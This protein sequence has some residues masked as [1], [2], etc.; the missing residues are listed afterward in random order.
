[1]NKH[2]LQFLYLEFK[3][4][5]VILLHS[6]FAFLVL[7]FLV[8]VAFI[9]VTFAA[10]SA[11]NYAKIHVG[12]VLPP[13]NQSRSLKLMTSMIEN[14]ESTSKIAEISY[15]GQ[16]EAYE[17]IRDGSLDAAIIIGDTF[18]NDVMTGINTPAIVLIPEE[19]ILNVD[20]FHELIDDGVS[21]IKT[22]ESA[23]YSVTECSFVKPMIVERYQ[24]E[25]FLTQLY[26][27]KAISL[28]T[29][30]KRNKITA[31]GNTSIQI[32]YASIAICILISFLGIIFSGLY[33]EQ[34]KVIAKKLK[35]Y[36]LGEIK[37]A[38]IR[39][40][41]I[42]VIVLVLFLLFSFGMDAL[43]K[44]MGKGDFPVEAD[45]LEKAL[46]EKDTVM[47]L[48]NPAKWGIWIIMS[49]SI[50][51]FFHTIL[52][53]SGNVWTNVMILIQSV[54]YMILCGGSIFPSA[55]LPKALDSISNLL[56]FGYWRSAV[57]ILWEKKLENGMELALKLSFFILAMVIILIL[58][59]FLSLYQ[60][61]KD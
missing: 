14:R 12:V 8:V 10:K 55:F 51:V 50:A 35:L 27:Q 11:E 5:F 29:M 42:S 1:M 56:P 15:L 53:L 13:D 37:I 4:S 49:V 24:M 32:Y 22:G 23:I 19:S 28:E 39:V 17:K 34:N 31:F 9:G 20:V 26:L 25:N 47:Y 60:R 52:S 7:M 48:N 43:I 36:G 57:A 40:F 16:E 33:N 38:A 41:V 59:Q 18:V 44:C 3:R 46:D 21:L 6:F 58:R 30:Y 2:T 45:I 61:R 54:F